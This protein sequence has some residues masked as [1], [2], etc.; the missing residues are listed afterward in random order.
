[1]SKKPK[2]DP[3]GIDA[4]ITIQGGG[5]FGL[6]LL[7]QARALLVDCKQP[8]VPLAFAGTSAGA[9]IAFLLWVG[10]TTHAII[11]RFVNHHKNTVGGL[12]SLFG[13][14]GE[15]GEELAKRF[16]YLSRV[17]AIVSTVLTSKWLILHPIKCYRIFRFFRTLYPGLFDG[18]ALERFLAT[19]LSE[20]P[21]FRA[22][23]DHKGA[24]DITFGDIR[25]AIEEGRLQRPALFV[26]IT[27][28]SKCS[29]ELVNT[30]D[31]RFDEYPICKTVRASA[32][33]PGVLKSPQI[34][35]MTC[36]DGGVVTN[37]PAWLYD[38][39]F[40]ERIRLSQGYA[41]Y[42]SRPWVHIGLRVIEKP[43]EPAVIT[44]VAS[45]AHRMGAMMLG[46]S[47]NILEENLSFQVPRSFIVN[48]P[49][50]KSG[51]PGGFLDIE[52]LDETTIR[53]MIDKGA[54]FAAKAF[55][56]L[57]HPVRTTDPGIER[58]LAELQDCVKAVLAP[59]TRVR[60]MLFVPVEASEGPSLYMTSEKGFEKPDQDRELVIPWRAGV[61]GR[62]YAAQCAVAS[63]IRAAADDA[64]A[65]DHAVQD[66]SVESHRSIP[67]DIRFA[68]AIP[69]F[70]PIDSY[71][72]PPGAA[73]QSGKIDFGDVQDLGRRGA[74]I[75][76]VCVDWSGPPN[77]GGRDAFRERN[78]RN[79]L[80]CLMGT[81]EIL[82]RL[83]T[84]DLDTGPR[85]GRK[86]SR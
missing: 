36:V 57:C 50:S 83:C 24:Q 26:S 16:K 47:R 7:G 21:D 62:A 59:V 43:E 64:I 27:N 20:H 52:K 10:L 38:R 1:M 45:L 86:G 84:S 55:A 58:E 33:I 28:L 60:T 11:E 17:Q 77:H 66:M 31:E 61:V 76:V 15:D 32:S 56:K 63:D 44:S 19:C 53:N 72:S 41:V 14:E 25:R 70:D 29:L 80:K 18:A 13:S 6:S 49:E 69:V 39:F 34:G 12:A 54:A 48:Q 5:L 79:V 51:A 37:F 85:D 82:G 3:G 81:A 71:M 67:A 74:V 22:L 75:G 9:I 78:T 4:V 40:R 23:L 35:N 46:R 30:L 73:S 65:N 42:G 8:I 2:V 68:V